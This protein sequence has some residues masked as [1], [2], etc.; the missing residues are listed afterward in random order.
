MLT[1][2]AVKAAGARPRAY[3]VADERGMHLHV[4]PTG[5]KSFRLKY[6]IG[7][8]E[9]LLVLGS[10]PEMSLS[11]ARD[12]RDQARALVKDG[13]D[14][15]LAR[16]QAQDE[17]ERA[18]AA[19][20]TF[21]Q[22]AR[23]WHGQ[24]APRWSAEHAG[25]VLG[26]LVNHAFPAIGAKRLADISSIEIL[27]LLQAIEGDGKPELARRLRQRISA[28]FCFA[29]ARGRAGADP[30]ASLTRELLGVEL[31]EHHPALLETVEVRALYL[32]VGA[33]DA[34]VITRLAHQML[35]LTA[36]RLGALRGA[37]WCE[38]AGVA[39][40]SDDDAPDAIWTIPAE[41]MKLKKARKRQAEFDHVVPLSRQ[42]VTILR[43]VR[44]LSEGYGILRTDDLIFRGRRRGRPIGERAIGELIDA[45]PFAGRHVP[46]GWRASFSTIMNERRPADRLVIDLALGHTPKTDAGKVDK[47]E[48]AY[49]RAKLLDARRGVLDA[50]AELLTAL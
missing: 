28:V 17:A 39:W 10:Y 31:V 42:A 1:N 40:D 36:T 45:T 2:A 35:A 6:R 7:R 5:H 44:R 43:G 32:T 49:N 8:R 47:V 38:I 34:P 48:A 16:R 12:R 19:E 37:R 29:I 14:P 22:V 27:D 20:A 9:K 21:D 3:K 25:D 4:S 13:V 41:R 50:W 23:E 15:M 46:H 24:R 18:A 30:A 11:E 26:S 33:L